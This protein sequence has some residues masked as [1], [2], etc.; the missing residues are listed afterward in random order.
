MRT[1][2]EASGKVLAAFHEYHHAGSFTQI[3]GI[4]YYTLKAMVEQAYPADSYAVVE[5][6]KDKIVIRG[7]VN[8]VS[9]EIVR[10]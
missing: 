1:V 7:F 9:Q 2:L 6:H 4:N 5:I 3:N 10:S 8:A